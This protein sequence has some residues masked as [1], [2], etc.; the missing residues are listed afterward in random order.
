METD[1]ATLA[2]K[3]RA[4]RTEWGDAVAHPAFEQQAAALSAADRDRLASLVFGTGDT[5]AGDKIGGDKV[6]GNKVRSSCTYEFAD[7]P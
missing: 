3:L 6:G 5:I 4:L 2:A 7:T 1:L